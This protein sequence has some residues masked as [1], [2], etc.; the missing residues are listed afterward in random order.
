MSTN[1]SITS[2]A[3]AGFYGAIF[4]TVFTVAFIL[5]AG[6]SGAVGQWEGVDSFMETYDQLRTGQ[7]LLSLSTLLLIP[8]FVTL[9]VGFHH[10]I[11][12]D[13]KVWS[14]I[15]VIWAGIYAA[16]LGINY[17]LQITVVPSNVAAGNKE[18]LQLL[19]MT[20]FDSAF[21]SLEAIGYCFM[22]LSTLFAAFALKA[23]G[24]ERW[25]KTLLIINGILG[26]A[27]AIFWAARNM[28]VMMVGLGLWCLLFP[29]TTILLA[30]Y[31]RRNRA[32]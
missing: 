6:F 10:F 24:L 32:E 17:Y 12:A 3:K 9:M 25:I 27:G 18:G 11:D 22:G 14:H 4:T 8:S 7:I 1:V 23:R 31:F 16:I 19:A 21:W 5:A 2:A 30:I 13:G 20:N 29:V 15:A 26:L 28:M